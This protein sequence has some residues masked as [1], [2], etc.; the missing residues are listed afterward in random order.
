MRQQ[1]V[2]FY[3]HDLYKLNSN[4]LIQGR[5]LAAEE[6]AASDRSV[7]AECFFPSCE[8]DAVQRRYL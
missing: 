1:E 3:P 7:K 2:V 4:G 8:D 6:K 5:V